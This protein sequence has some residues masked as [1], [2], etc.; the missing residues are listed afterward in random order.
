M[1][2]VLTKIDTYC[3]QVVKQ[4][5]AA[6]RACHWDY[7][8][9]IVANG[10]SIKAYY[11]AEMYN[12]KDYE[13]N[14]TDA[15][16]IKVSM[17]KADYAKFLFPHRNDFKVTITRTEKHESAEFDLESPRRYQKTYKGVLVNQT[18]AELNSQTNIPKDESAQESEASLAFIT[19][20]IQL[21]EIASEWIAKTTMGGIVGNCTGA[22]VARFMVGEQGRLAEVDEGLKIKGVD[23]VPPDVTEKQQQMVIDHGT[24]TL[25]IPSVIQSQWGGLY[26]NGLGSYIRDQFV[27]IYP[28][29]A[30]NRFQKE[31]KKVTIVVVPRAL[32]GGSKRT[33]YTNNGELVLMVT[34]EVTQVDT[35]NIQQMAQGNGLTYFDSA[36]MM[37]DAM[38]RESGKVI[39]NPEEAV[40]SFVTSKREDKMDFAPFSRQQYS[41]N[42]ADTLSQTAMAN[43]RYMTGLWEWSHPDL[44]EP[45]LPV[46]VIYFK[47]DKKHEMFGTLLKAS[48][49]TVLDGNPAIGRYRTNTGLVMFVQKEPSIQDLKQEEEDAKG[50]EFKS[51]LEMFGIKL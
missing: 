16:I 6:P 37:G 14:F 38:P 15:I 39:P 42:M 50:L 31:R 3:R 2:D 13:V 4:C 40:N 7:N 41:R 48:S 44:L 35:A 12:V 21:I 29:Y 30:L 43:G 25:A 5:G 10:K 9:S 36:K 49:I 20:N 17:K 45:A 22:D 51:V 1:A 46:R 24:P 11:I 19:V 32:I 28:L 27:Y 18:D 33:Y 34:D 8:A 47:E 23:M 26:N